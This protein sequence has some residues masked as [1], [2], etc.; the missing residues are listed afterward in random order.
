RGARNPDRRRG[1]DRPR[2]R[3]APA[4]KL[5]GPDRV[6]G[7]MSSPYAPY[8]MNPYAAPQAGYAPAYAPV[9]SHGAALK[10][11]YLRALVGSIVFYG[12]AVAL[13]DANDGDA[14]G[15]IGGLAIFVAVGFFVARY[16]LGLVWLY[17]SWSAIPPEFRMNRSG[18][19]I[20]P[21]QAVGYMF[22]PFYN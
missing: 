13:A 10:W 12:A 6:E 14:A 16:I 17:K 18:R 4:G 3:E 19:L 5:S 11:L 20:S 21:G 9:G 7:A 22:I 1:R 8:G 15:L 2:A